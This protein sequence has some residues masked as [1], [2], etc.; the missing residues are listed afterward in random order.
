MPVRF[1]YLLLGSFESEKDYITLGDSI[2]CLMSDRSFHE[3]AYAAKTQEELQAA[4]N[5]YL[6]K[7]SY[8]NGVVNESF[9]DHEEVNESTIIQNGGTHIYQ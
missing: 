9:I 7:S 2:S 3:V 1:V 6:K 8:V 5:H 4:M